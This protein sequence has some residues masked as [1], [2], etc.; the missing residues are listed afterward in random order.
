MISVLDAVVLAALALAGWRLWN[1]TASPT[2][3]ALML[4][5]LVWIAWVFV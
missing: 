2:T 1:G 4:T 5:C 3:R